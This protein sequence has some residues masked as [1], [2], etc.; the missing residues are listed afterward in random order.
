MAISNF[1]KITKVN[2]NE[3][4]TPLIRQPQKAPVVSLPTL[5]EFVQKKTGVKT[6]LTPSPKILQ[7]WSQALKQE[8]KRIQ[9]TAKAVATKKQVEAKAKEAPKFEMSRQD[10]IDAMLEK[11]SWLKS[12]F[13]NG[14]VTSDDIFAASLDKYKQLKQANDKWLIDNTARVQEEVTAKWPIQEDTSLL[15]KIWVGAA[16]IPAGIQKLGTDIWST[17]WEKILGMDMTKGRE[18]AQNLENKIYGGSKQV[19]PGSF[20]TGKQVGKQIGI[21]ALTPWA[22][23]LKWVSTLWKTTIWALEWA[24]QAQLTSLLDKWRLASLKETVTWAGIWWAL[25]GISGIWQKWWSIAQTEKLVMPKL[26]PSEMAS[27]AKEWLTS[28]SM[29]GKVTAK[30]SKAE[31]ELAQRFQTILRPNKTVSSNINTVLKELNKETDNLINVVKDKPVIFNPKEITNKMRK[32]EKPLMIRGWE[33]ESKYNAVIKKFEEILSKKPKTAVWLL[34]SRKE[35][36]SWINAEIPNLYTSD[37]MTPLK[38]AITKIRKVPNEWLNEKIWGDVVKNSLSKQSQMFDIVDNLKSKIESE[39]STA[40][41]RWKKRNPWKAQAIWWG[42]LAWGSYL[43]WK[44]SNLP[45]N[46]S[47]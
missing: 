35:L 36:D 16:G 26:T 1:P 30:A 3:L 41:A 23:A 8:G 13:D 4:I 20:E 24:G 38:V 19:S 5:W 46:I 10:V 18:Y 9:E 42:A 11:H 12:A 37:T 21:T 15:T 29:F 27:R 25:R 40:L 7:T 31:K 6:E 43:I 39:G 45:T 47:E 2:K 33:N 28:T 17:I 32:L 14:E 22:G 44:K 34:E